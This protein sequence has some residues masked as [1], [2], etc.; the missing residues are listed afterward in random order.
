MEVKMVLG[1]R[2]SD[3]TALPPL[4]RI[5]VEDVKVIGKYREVD[6]EKIKSL[7]ASMST[8]IGLRTPITVRR[9]KEGLGTTAFALVAGLHRLKAATTLGW[10]HIDAFI[11]EGTQTDAR[12]WQ[13]MENLY[14]AE[15]TPLQRAEHVAELGPV[16]IW[17]SA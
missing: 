14:R 16:E 1:N 10:K 9:I 8:K 13:L 4:E 3:N 6:P 15:L 12:I 5:A 2:S 11:M 17:D 7:A